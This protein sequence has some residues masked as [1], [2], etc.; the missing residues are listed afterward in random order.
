MVVVD[1]VGSL[2]DLGGPPR[3][4]FATAQA[5]VREADVIVAVCDA[6]PVGVARL[7]AW[8]VDARSLAPSHAA[9]SSS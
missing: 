7:L 8:T 9:W 1:G 5:L 2:Q 4:R 3:G 6:S